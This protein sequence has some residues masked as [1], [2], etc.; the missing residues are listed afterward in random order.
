MHLAQD[1]CLPLTRAPSSRGGDALECGCTSAMGAVGCGCPAYAEAHLHLP[2][3]YGVGLLVRA[4]TC[5][6]GA[7]RV[8]LG[9]HGGASARGDR[10]QGVGNRDRAWLCKCVPARGGGTVGSFVLLRCAAG[11]RCVLEM[12]CAVPRG[13]C[14]V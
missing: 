4:A 7:C 6:P 11:A 1:L 8:G 13:L 3:F 14:T 9:C 12:L 2:G 10:S 5:P